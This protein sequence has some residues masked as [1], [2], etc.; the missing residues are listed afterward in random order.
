MLRIVYLVVLTLFL[1]AATVYAAEPG[2]AGGRL[3]GSPPAKNAGVGLADV[4]WTEGFWAERWELCRREMLPS[5]ERALLD[6]AN[7]EQLINLRSLP[8]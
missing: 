2:A 8:A 6:E 3:P 7:S 5:V 4:R 1:S